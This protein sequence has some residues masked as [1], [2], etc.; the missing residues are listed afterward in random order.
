V[1]QTLI[2]DKRFE[3]VGRGMYT[4]KANASS[5]A[6]KTGKKRSNKRSSRSS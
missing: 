4:A 3:R 6:K 5:D 2:K 1:N